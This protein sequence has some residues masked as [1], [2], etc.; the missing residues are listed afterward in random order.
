MRESTDAALL[1]HLLYDVNNLDF[2]GVLAC[3]LQVAMQ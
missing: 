3:L 1:M 2:Q